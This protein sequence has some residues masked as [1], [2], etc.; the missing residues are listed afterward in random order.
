MEI[1]EER[2]AARRRDAFPITNSADVQARSERRANAKNFR[3]R[4][5]L[6]RDLPAAQR[7]RRKRRSE[8]LPATYV[9]A[10]RA[11]GWQESRIT[12]WGSS[13]VTIAC[14]PPAASGWRILLA[15]RRPS[16]RMGRRIVVSEGNSRAAS[17]PSSKPT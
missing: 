16:S 11:G 13:G 5:F 9:S 10:Y 12:R 2:A 8:S 14:V 3:L 17:G 7:T 6:K 1:G 4:K 15:A